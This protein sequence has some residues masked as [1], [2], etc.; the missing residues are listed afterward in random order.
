VYKYSANYL[1]QCLLIL[2]FR[3]FICSPSITHRPLA[4]FLAA[5]ADVYGAVNMSQIMNL[6]AI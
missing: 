3:A 1:L 6:R 5:A 2:I 4:A